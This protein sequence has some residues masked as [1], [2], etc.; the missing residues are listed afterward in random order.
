[1]FWPINWRDQL[2]KTN[3]KITKDNE[4][5]VIA[6]HFCFYYNDA[7]LT[8]LFAASLQSGIELDI[9]IKERY[10]NETPSHDEAHI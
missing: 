1:M 3:S 5:K 9:K 2:H 4:E 6:L 7:F 10:Y 8:I